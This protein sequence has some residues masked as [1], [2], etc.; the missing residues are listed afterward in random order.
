[1]TTV[2]RGIAVSVIVL[3]FAGASYGL[4]HWSVRSSAEE[5]IAAAEAHLR[6]REFREARDELK[7]LL[8]SDPTHHRAL[9][10]TGVSLNGDQ[11]YQ[12]AIRVLEQIP[13]DSETAEQAGLALASSLVMDG[14]WERAE[15][16]LKDQVDRFPRSLNAC[17]ELANLYL[18]QLRKREGDAVFLAYW[19]RNRDE[20]AILSDLLDAATRDLPP[21]DRVERLEIADARH[22]DQASVVLALARAYHRMGMVVRARERFDSA[23]RLRPTDPAT[24][25]AVAEFHLDS[26]DHEA[27]EALLAT[28]SEAELHGTIHSDRYWFVRAQIAE[29]GGRISESLDL[30]QRAL[31]L[32]PDDESYLLM[33]ASLLRRSGRLEES[34]ESAEAAAEL[35]DARA[36]LLLLANELGRGLANSDR[37]FMIADLLERLGHSEQAADW[38]RVGE[39]GRAAPP[40]RR[41]L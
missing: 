38:R 16:V 10:I 26:G 40:G 11:Q 12:D 33:Q 19:E 27:A 24:V 9:L 17:R 14:Q 36:Q 31:E 37:C 34:K 7:W 30:L 13:D 28:V 3:V 1:M 8:W 6:R 22:P 23:L 39:G 32:R 4:V 5:T 15:F 29:Q 18:S 25:I 2:R 20:F 41:V 21:Q 35:A